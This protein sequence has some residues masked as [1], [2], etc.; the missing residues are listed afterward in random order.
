MIRK[1]GFTVE[2]LV[3]NTGRRVPREKGGG[4]DPELGADFVV[5]VYYRDEALCPGGVPNLEVPEV[6]EAIFQAINYNPSRPDPVLDLRSVG[7]FSDGY[8]IYVGLSWP[9]Q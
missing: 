1:A 5:V 9:L 2:M 7:R 8:L 4:A 3:G 6:R